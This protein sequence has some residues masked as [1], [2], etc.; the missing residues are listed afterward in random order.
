MALSVRLREV[1]LPHMD[2]T[3]VLGIVLAA[4]AGVLVLMLTRPASSTPILVASSTIQPGQPLSEADVT[5]RY[6]EN[7]DGLVVGASLG[8]LED[9]TVR[10]PVQPGEPL[11]PSLLQA[12]ELLAAP[13]VV[14]LT[15]APAH[16]VQGRL[17][18]GDRVDVY[19]T[20]SG[21]FEVDGTT[22][23]IAESVYVVEATHIDDGIGQ[24]DVELLLAVDDALAAV[25]VAA[26][27]LGE[28]NLVR[29]AP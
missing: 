16:A 2:R 27:R 23:L 24:A 4:L 14:A 10:V 13:N 21:S 5:V 1:G 12:P 18:A 20:T 7:T 19:R 3:R 9:W 8:E 26:D 25:I 29:V 11:V 15:L 17:V 28:I 22:E 6:V